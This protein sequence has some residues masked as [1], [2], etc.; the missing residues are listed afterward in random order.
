MGKVKTDTCAYFMY[1]VRICKAGNAFL[2]LLAEYFSRVPACCDAY[3]AEFFAFLAAL[4]VLDELQAFVW[5][6]LLDELRAFV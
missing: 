3:C 5:L 2:P 1:I 6:L 4:L